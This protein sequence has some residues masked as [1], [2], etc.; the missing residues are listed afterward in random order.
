MG[1][2][3]AST[4]RLNESLEREEL[5]CGFHLC[6]YVDGR[7]KLEVKSCETLVARRSREQVSLPEIRDV[8]DLS[9]LFAGFCTAQ[10]E[11]GGARRIDSTPRS[12]CPRRPEAYRW[13][14]G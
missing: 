14:T 10:L 11:S 8:F 5:G 1:E 3:F 7:R 2:H 6:C 4:C 13:E 12:V 9:L